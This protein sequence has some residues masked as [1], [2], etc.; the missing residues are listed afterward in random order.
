MEKPEYYTKSEYVYNVIKEDILS[1]RYA[2]G[3]KIVIRSIAERLNTSDIPVREAMRKLQADNLVNM[4]PH[5][6]ATVTC[7]STQEI[8][9]AVIIRKLLEPIAGKLAVER[10]NEEKKN[11]LR[12]LIDRMNECIKNGDDKLYGRLN[13]EFH[14]TIYEECGNNTL[15]NIIKDL[16]EKTERTRAIFRQNPQRM[17]EAN[18]EHD[19]LYKAICNND[20]DMAEKTIKFQRELAEKLYLDSIQQYESTANK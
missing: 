15:Y 11:I 5:V 9:E 20:A 12:N 8:K 4:V 6:G 19:E 14:L 13:K 3:E 10:L 17:K 1:G 16:M 18:E 2:S 7:V